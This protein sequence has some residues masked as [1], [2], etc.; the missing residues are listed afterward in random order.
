MIVLLMILRPPRSTRTDT[1]FPY[2]TRFR[3]NPGGQHALA[4]KVRQLSTRLLPAGRCTI[5]QVAKYLGVDRRTVH[6]QLQRSGQSFS[7]IV[8]AVRQDQVKRYLTQG[9][10]SLAETTDLLGFSA[11]SAL[12]P[13]FLQ[14]IRPTAPLWP[15]H[16]R[17]LRTA[18]PR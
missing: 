11:T 1:R 12:L 15:P 14:P 9:C 3:S 16:N 7:D 18:P 8:C 6:R 13:R 5:E 10:R 2:T 4:D 17:T